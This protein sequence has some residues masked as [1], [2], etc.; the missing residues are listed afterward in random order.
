MLYL[1][2]DQGLTTATVR[3]ESPLLASTLIGGEPPEIDRHALNQE[4]ARRRF[5]PASERQNTISTRVKTKRKEHRSSQ[6]RHLREADDLMNGVDVSS[7]DEPESLERKLA[8]LK[9][10][11]SEVKDDLQE[12]KLNANESSQTGKAE[13]ESQELNDLLDV[14]QGQAVHGK[15]SMTA[16]LL[17]QF[18]ILSDPS[19]AS[20]T[21][22]KADTGKDGTKN[23]STR[24]DNDDSTQH[25]SS[26]SLVHEFD[27]RLKFLE[28]SLGVELTQ[29]NQ[30]GGEPT[31]PLL[32]TMD[33]LDRQ[34]GILSRST[35]RTVEQL[36]ERIHELVQEAASLETKQAQVKPVT[37][38]GLTALENATQTDGIEIFENAATMSKVNALYGT[39]GII[40]SM[41]P[42]LPSVLDRLRS[43]KE[44]HAN[45]V[46]A[47]QNLTELEMDQAEMKEE[48]HKW[49]EGLEKAET[50]MVLSQKS[51]TEN[52]KSVESWVRDL[53]HRFKDLS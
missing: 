17:Q 28:D 40:E 47:G 2:T 34:L 46:S 51:S 16:R 3:S 31:K 1:P 29:R 11:L 18:S 27:T 38:K 33:K 43:L 30:Q 42:L 20:G 44:L 50:A 14:I 53:E 49:R 12:Q 8:R 26:L 39:L 25:E 37:Q 48:I 32:P 22:S 36:G 24:T 45:A 15:P 6:G 41:A 35:D 23:E 19:A 10:E 4:E 7:E 52:L 9:R 5:Q 21:R 13:N